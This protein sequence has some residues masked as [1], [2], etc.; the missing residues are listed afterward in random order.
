[1]QEIK[2]V[3]G[4]SLEIMD[5]EEMN[6]KPY[7]YKIIDKFFDKKQIKKILKSVENLD[8]KDATHERTSIKH[9]KQ[10]YEYNK[11][12][13]TDFEK[14]DNSMKEVFMEL[15]SEKFIYYL[16]KLTGIKNLICNDYTLRGA[17]IHRIKRGGFLQMHTDFNTYKHPKYGK[18]DRRINLLVYLNKEWKDSYNGHLLIVDKESKKIVEKI[19]PIVNKCVIF[20]T[21]KDSLHGHPEE[22]NTPDNIDRE[23]LAMYYYTKNENGGVDFEG[24]KPHSTL[25]YE[26]EY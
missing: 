21:C 6:T 13:F 2:Y 19:E 7:K 1:M 3:R 15:T 9:K 25:W 18:L 17:G 8:D 10:G 16:E 26:L 24:D 11:L 14:L 20:N 23:S 12:S 22:L 4:K 5:K